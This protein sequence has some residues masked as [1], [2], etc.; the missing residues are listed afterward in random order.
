VAFQ[1][2]VVVVAGEAVAPVPTTDPVVEPPDVRSGPG[3]AAADTAS[4]PLAG[5]GNSLWALI[6]ACIGGGL[7]ALVMPCTYPMIPITFT[8]F[9]KQADARGG[10]V[11][12]LALTY[13]LGIVVMF[14]AI[15][16]LAGVVGDK[17]VE[18]SAHWI[19]NVVI[20]GAFL[21]FALS[22]L[23][24]ITI[25]PPAF[26]TQAAGKSRSVGGVLGVLLMG[27]TLVISSFTCTAPIVALLL[28]PAVQTGDA[29]KPAIGMA[30]FGLTMALPFVMLALLPGRVKALPR[31]GEWMNTLK[32]SLGVI[33]LAAALKFF[34][35]AEYAELLYIL[36]R[37]VFFAIWIALFGAL[38]VYLFGL[39]PKAQVGTGRRIGGAA[40]LL[41]AG[42][43]L[44]GALGYPQDFVMN[45]LAPAYGLK[46]LH[47]E[48]IV[49][50]EAGHPR[51]TD[52]YEAAVAH[53]KANGK[54]VLVNFTGFTCSNCRM[55]E[56][57][58][59]PSA[60]IAPL[61]KEH[62][63]EARL[64]M[65]NPDRIPAAQWQV[66]AGLRQTLMGGLTTT[67]SYAA[68]DPTTGAKLADHVL[69]GGPGAWEAGYLAFL[70]Q[71]L[72]K[73][74]RSGAVRGQ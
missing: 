66:Q 35:N 61:L 55:V 59:L 14:T 2:T 20:G 16:A 56:R 21:V 60:N 37:E 8:F 40:S 74:G 70:Q 54:L 24:W 68:V 72:Q 13:G 46:D 30:V 23:G 17:I 10:K 63:V 39:L 22:L 11:L 42:Y 5:L 52:D 28:L 43:C 41:F 1:A 29:S 18:F 27:A 19:T 64:H 6:L 25:Q 65:D 62:F 31:S 58:I 26:L 73:A 51:A 67:P 34:S 12:T 4:D 32:V 48:V 9:T 69:S 49:V 45:A 50:D 33:E 7:F 36:P 15:G 71:S 47:K 53:A 44:Y 57:G 3:V 38:A